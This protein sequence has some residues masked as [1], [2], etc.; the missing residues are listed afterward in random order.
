MIKDNY[1]LISILAVFSKIFETIIAEQWNF[2]K[3]LIVC[4]MY[5]LANVHA[6]G[7]STNACGLMSS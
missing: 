5:V 2:L 4:H 7:L 1:R 6:Y 3:S